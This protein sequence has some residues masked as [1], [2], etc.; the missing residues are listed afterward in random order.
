MR[1]LEIGEGVI[2]CAF[3]SAGGLLLAGD[4][5]GRAV[6]VDS[7]LRVTWETE[8]DLPVWGVDLAPD[9]QLAAFALADKPNLRGALVIFDYA[10]NRLVE[11]IDIDAPGWDVLFDPGGQMVCMSTWGEGIIWRSLSS[12]VQGSIRIPGHIFGLRWCDSLGAEPRMLTA[13][14]SGVGVI[15]IDLPAGSFPAEQVSDIRM[16]LR[17]DHTCYKH[18]FDPSRTTLYVG[19]A[20]SVAPYS[21]RTRESPHASVTRTF[22]TLTRDVCAVACTDKLLI[23]GSLAGEIQVSR[24]EKPEMATGFSSI[25]NGVWNVTPSADGEKVFVARGDGFIAEYATASMESAGDVQDIRL[26]PGSLAGAKVFL[27]YASEDYAEVAGIYRYLKTLGCVPWMDRFDILPGQ[28]WE[29]EIKKALR[30]SDFIVICFSP[31]SVT[32]RGYIQK[33]VR[34]ALQ[35][36]DEVPDDDIFVI[37]A[38]LRECS[39]PDSL[40]RRQWVD[41]F[42][43]DGLHR[44]CSA[45]YISLISRDRMS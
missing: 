6:L 18:V 5:S 20:T 31:N 39:I 7:N 15:G 11:R 41:L 25:G 43:K 29:R 22:R 34:V 8:F 17:S 44:L 23:Q 14:L 32:K 12:E 19:S 35:L 2:D 4:V 10:E 24:L 42:E 40:S 3:D 28:D 9:R 30:R 13:T 37:P 27:S 38:R 26:G 16:L 1:E 33:E 45:I 36:L 21:R